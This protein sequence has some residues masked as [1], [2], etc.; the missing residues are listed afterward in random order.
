V[1]TGGATNEYLTNNFSGTG[2]PG[3]ILDV[4]K[5]KELGASRA[6]DRDRNPRD[7]N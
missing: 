1:G 3:I 7:R 4:G 6:I 2:R 5:S